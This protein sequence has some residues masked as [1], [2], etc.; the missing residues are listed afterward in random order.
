MTMADCGLS[1]PSAD[2]N[3]NI[4]QG[5]GAS[6]HA[7][8]SK[9][10][11]GIGLEVVCVKLQKPPTQNVFEKI[12]KERRKGVNPVIVFCR[13]ESQAWLFG[14]NPESPALN[15]LSIERAVA[16]LQECLN[17][18]TGFAA[19]QRFAQ[20]RDAIR[21]SDKASV[22][23]SGLFA[24]HHIR[25]NLPSLSIWQ[26]GMEKAKPIV[27][28][29][30]RELIKALGFTD[31]MGAENT[32]LLSPDST[33]Q[34]R[35]VAVLLN[36][37]E[38][39]D[40]RSDKYKLTPVAWGLKVAAENEV[41]WLIVLRGGQIRLYP[42]KDGVGVGQRSQVDTY[43]ELDLPLLEEEEFPYLHLIFS[44][45][46]LIQGGYTE[47]ILSDSAKYASEL[48][49]RLRSRIYDAVVP[50]LS[51]GV[52]E[53]LPKLG[54]DLT[55]ENLQLAYRLTL[56]ILFRLIFQAYAEDRG[57][58]PFERNQRYT[59]NAL[60]TIAVRDLMDAEATYDADSVSLWD[61]LQQVWKVIDSGDKD[62][63]VPAY[64]GG[65]FGSDPERHGEGS[66]IRKLEIPNSVMGPALEALLI[67][68]TEEDIK[69]PVDFRSLS[70][71]EFGTIYE[72]LLES[73]LSLAPED[74]TLD[75]NGAWV[76]AGK[77]DVIEAAA[78]T[79]YFHNSS[80]ERKAT[81]SYFTPSIIVEHLLDR[82]LEPALE[83]H[84]AEVSELIKAG[85]ENSAAEKFFDFRV[86]D[87]AM[88]S[89]H[90]LV[91][92]V[93]RIETAFRN[94]LVDNSI[95]AVSAELQRL[96]LAA[97]DALG[98]DAEYIG[99]IEQ[100][101]L[102]RRQVARRCIYGIDINEMAVELARLALWIH[103]FVPGLPMSSLDHGLVCANSLTGIGTFDEVIDI[104]DVKGT[105]F[106]SIMLEKL[107]EAKVLL[108]EAANASEANKQEVLKNA[109][110]LNK[111][112]EAVEPIRK[113]FDSAVIQRTG[114][115]NPKSA[116]FDDLVKNADREEVVSAI[117][118]LQPA[119][120]PYL[121]PEVFVRSNAGFDVIIG[122]PPFLNRI[123]NETRGSQLQ[124]SSIKA[125]FRRLGKG[126]ANYASIFLA[127]A[128]DLLKD[129]GILVFIQPESLVS[130]KDSKPVRDYILSRGSMVHLWV[131]TENVFEGA[132]VRTIAPV[133][134]KE[135]GKSSL[136]RSI[137]LICEEVSTTE[138][139]KSATTWGH[140]IA[141]LY[142]I[143]RVS[144]LFGKESLS[145]IAEIQSGDFIGNFYKISPHLE[146]D[147]NGELHV[148]T[149][150]I[151]DLLQN[152]WGRKQ[153]KINKNKYLYPSI[154][155][156]KLFSIPGIQ[157]WA[158]QV[159]RRKILLATQT[160][161]IEFIIDNDGNLIP[162][163]PAISVIPRNGVDIFELATL[164]MTP[165][166][167]A[168][169]L[170]QFVGAGMTS[171][172]LKLSKS[173]IEAIPLP[174]NRE[175][176]TQA[177]ALLKNAL[178]TDEFLLTKIGNLM[179]T[180]YELPGDLA[181]DWWVNQK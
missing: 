81:G 93:D 128:F 114:V 159:L 119:H 26:T 152:H 139:I 170:N 167:N 43:F 67:D 35:A 51:K 57:L 164:F 54:L 1:D 86:A 30:G 150:G 156:E 96:E 85:K 59:D 121:F 160:R 40:A 109:E 42:A 4:A 91:A 176:W 12:Y 108:I 179:N 34:P 63:N 88:G 50:T 92:A 78:G 98:S 61:D 15:P 122:N 137:K 165:A 69:G 3:V 177:S 117:E 173:Q 102:L 41:P 20:I 124:L 70:V 31:K 49:T 97:K 161:R 68:D 142:G 16:I 53:Q 76:P 90:F 52:A 73:S 84:L 112:N 18:S 153:T 140:L 46:A 80:G 118:L 24:S 132:A 169:L 39:F 33:K 131:A 75:R 2:F 48:G 58:L 101:S 129:S 133:F 141:D 175:T 60:K 148:I 87:L 178:S 154:S 166:L 107:N 123:E 9:D 71:R 130:T 77:D 163:V 72:G 25:K 64:N 21:S 158:V 10:P 79:A 104:L 135:L 7:H 62:W 56:R 180:S 103:T 151:I 181:L 23:N 134:H 155:K 47:Q 13:T 22:R 147:V 89:A 136:T 113:V 19:S 149:V 171:E 100:A 146:D 120:Y 11:H 82:A 143:P 105:L 111:A 65:L 157:N 94:F 5:Q 116:E 138:I 6:A 127:Q 66:L 36:E 28:L 144:T 95:P 125:K 38:N 126:Y 168:Y 106:E 83:K 27:N 32:L 74:L 29:R 8:L 172:V 37:D 110:I 55:S 115:F 162:S 145:S 14:P 45:E 44:V 99:D 17:E 174:I